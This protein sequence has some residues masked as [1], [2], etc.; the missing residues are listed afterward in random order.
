[1]VAGEVNL[2][3]DAW[4]ASNKDGYFAVT[5]HWIE[6]S[7]PTQW[8][9]KSSLLGFIRLNNAHNGKRLGQALFKVIKRVGIEHKTGHITCDNASNNTTMMQEL[10][11]RL[12]AAT[13]EEYKWRKMKINCLAHVINLATQTLI[14]AY[15]K[16]PH[17]DP[18]NPEAHVPTSRDE[19]GL[20]R[21]ISVEERSSSKRKEMWKTVQSEAGVTSPVQLILD[22]KVRWSST[23][24]M[25]VRAEQNKTSVDTFIDKLHPEEPDGS[26]RDKIRALKLDGDEWERVGLFL[27]LLA[28]ANKAQQA[29]SSDQ[30]PT[31]HLAIPALEALH[32]AWSSRA[33][34]PKYGRFIPALEAACVKIDK[35]YEKTTESPAYLMAMILNPKE[36][37]SYFKKHWSPE[38]QGDVVE[39]VEKVFKER[40]LL[41]S[42]GSDHQ[43]LTMSTKWGLH[44]LLRELSDDEVDTT[45]TGS[46]ALEDPGQPWTQYFRA[47]MD[48]VEQVPDGWSPIKWWGVNCSRYHAAWASLARDYLSIMSSSIS[49]ERAF[50]QGGI[51]ISKRRN[52][53]KGDIVEMLQCMKCAIRHDLLFREP[54]PSSILEAEFDDGSRDGE[55]S[56]EDDQDV[57]DDDLLL[58]GEDDMANTTG[59]DTGLD[60]D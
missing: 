43:E 9:I 44:T 58:E 14:S 15:S 34:R 50:S 12:K 5:C 6:E 25:L 18:K 37:M 28:H 22:M 53:L 21:A 7:I 10:A 38:L 16:A 54:G 46:N 17:F 30:T 1:M 11:T 13:G 23:Y 8:E 24:L 40:Y 48:T 55:D 35:Y 4:Q 42:K 56:G 49:S 32:R 57:W 52:R 39:C 27:D 29:F 36:K 31:L 47:Y 60:S 51:T 2:T 20:V 19:V 33:G 3:C 59:M 26:K 45:E 41:L